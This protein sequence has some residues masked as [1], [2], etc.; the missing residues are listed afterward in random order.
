MR[1]YT[2]RQRVMTRDRKKEASVST[3]KRSFSLRSLAV[4]AA[5]VAVTAVLLTGCAG[6]EAESVSPEQTELRVVYSSG[7]ANWKACLEDVAEKFME[8]NPE[9]SV[10]LYTMGNYENRLYS[11]QLKILYAEDEFYDVLELREPQKVAEAGIL[12]EIPDAVEQL[13]DPARLSEEPVTYIPIYQMNRGMVY[14]KGVF[15][16]LGIREPGTYE[17]FLDACETLKEAGYNPVAVGGA[18][19]WHMEFWGN[20][21][22][23]N[24]MLD[25]DQQIQWTEENAEAMLRAFRSLYERGYVA[26]EYRDLSDNE[27]AREIAAGNAAMLYTGAWMMP[28]ITGMNPDVDLGYFFLPGPGGVRYAAQ[29][30]SNCW[31]ISQ[32]CAE[33]SEKYRA[34]ERF[35]TFFYSEG[36]YE[37]VLDT[38]TADSV[39]RRP[40][41]ESG[42]E[43]AR[44]VKEAY[45][46]NVVATD[47][48]I[49]SLDT[50]GGF[51][52]NYNRIMREALWGSRPI[53]ELAAELIALWQEER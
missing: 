3:E 21:L 5:S 23:D 26:E 50:P 29:D 13:M 39:V 28:Q 34:A 16:Q 37:N 49:S 6:Q 31:G 46:E 52:N 4:T 7:D 51:R 18:D 47:Q 41:E 53:D 32:K 11:D 10:E 36:I 1:E 45:D 17:E 12:A 2:N 33:D 25:Q 22:F 27:T 8:E 43:A 14:N 19:L 38:M 30:T 48:I 15:Q 24:Y 42:L 9:I 20:F 40:V 35:L 44:L